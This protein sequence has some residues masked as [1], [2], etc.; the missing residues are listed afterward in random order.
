M[1]LK[2]SS[3]PYYCCWAPHRI[4][5]KALPLT[6]KMSLSQITES[7][8]SPE[9]THQPK[10]LNYLTGVMSLECCKLQVL[11]SEF[12]K[13]IGTTR[14]HHAMSQQSELFWIHFFKVPNR[15]PTE[16]LR[17]LRAF[18]AHSNLSLDEKY[19]VGFASINEMS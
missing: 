1:L 12:V 4:G 15:M 10:V 13:Q 7:R 11:Q 14:T 8:A 6:P 2:G 19:I 17:V 3:L 18:E 5:R 16:S 9:N